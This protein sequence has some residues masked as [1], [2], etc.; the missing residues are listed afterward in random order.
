MESRI[1]LSC[2]PRNELTICLL[3]QSLKVTNEPP[4]GIK[5]G[6]LKTYSSVVTAEKLDIFEYKEW[7]NLVFALSLFKV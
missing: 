2:E 4:K 1:W 5:A 7:K 6:M 3:H